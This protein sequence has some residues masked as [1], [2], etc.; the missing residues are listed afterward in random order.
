MDNMMHEDAEE[1]ISKSNETHRKHISD[2]ISKEDIKKYNFS[3]LY[4]TSV[5]LNT[6]LFTNV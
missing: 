3:F 1:M 5:I 4:F 2:D 6:N